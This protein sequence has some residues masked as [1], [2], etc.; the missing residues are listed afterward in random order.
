MLASVRGHHPPANPG[1]T[2]GIPAPSRCG[3]QLDGAFF[4]WQLTQFGGCVIVSTPTRRTT[5]NRITD[6]RS[7]LQLIQAN[8]QIQKMKDASNDDLE[9]EVFRKMNCAYIND[10]LC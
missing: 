3:E 7:E 5:W 4:Y 1:S 8:R 9:D 2:P 10:A 6:D